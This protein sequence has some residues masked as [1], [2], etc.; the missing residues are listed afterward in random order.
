MSL[1]DFFIAGIAVVFILGIVR[2]S[3][4]IIVTLGILWLVLYWPLMFTGAMVGDISSKHEDVAP[5]TAGP[6]V[7]GSTFSQIWGT[8]STGP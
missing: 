8:G 6:H 5:A 4:R 3:F 2:R 7:P 1:D